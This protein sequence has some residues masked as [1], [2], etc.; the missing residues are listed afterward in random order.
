VREFCSADDFVGDWRVVF[1]GTNYP[2]LEFKIINQ[3]LPG[4]EEDYEPVC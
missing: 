3:T 1:R 2:N 4:D